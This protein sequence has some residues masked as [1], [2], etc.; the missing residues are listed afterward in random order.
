VRPT[1]STWDRFKV[2]AGSYAE[3]GFEFSI[4]NNVPSAISLTNGSTPVTCTAAA[5]SS[6]SSCLK[7]ALGTIGPTTTIVGVQTTSL[8]TPGG[9]WDVHLT[10]KFDPGK[11]HRFPF[12][13]TSD[14]T[15]DFFFGRPAD[16]H[17]PTETREAVLWTSSINLPVWGN[18]TVSPTYS[19]FFYRPQ[20]ST[21]YEQFRNF[22]I[23]LRWYMARDQRVPLQRQVQLQGP[24][25]MDQ[26][27]TPKK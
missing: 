18:L 10:R 16:K 17:L 4:Q 1:A 25:S 3:M 22:S 26:T 19:D 7:T 12:S 24:P 11:Q 9:Y 13:L 8:H 15:G 14:T 2:D 21:V 27:K 6:F 23:A 20:N 5:G